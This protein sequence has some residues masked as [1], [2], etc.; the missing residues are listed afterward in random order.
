MGQV[1][2]S[3]SKLAKLSPRLF[4]TWAG[5]LAAGAS[6]AAASTASNMPPPAKKVL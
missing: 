6:M 4:S 1:N 2:L 5:G 3:L